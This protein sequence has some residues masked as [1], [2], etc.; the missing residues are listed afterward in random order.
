MNRILMFHLITSQLAGSISITR[1]FRVQSAITENRRYQRKFIQNNWFCGVTLPSHWHHL[2]IHSVNCS[3]IQA[4]K[5][6]WEDWY[7]RWEWHGFLFSIYH[8]PLTIFLNEQLFISKGTVTL[9]SLMCMMRTFQMLNTHEIQTE[10]V[11]K[12]ALINISE[13]CSF[14]CLTCCSLITR[15]VSLAEWC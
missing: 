5:L 3:K 7:S 11:R 9:S 6:T 4:Y 2:K 8:N 10:I 15:T 14:S 1:N 13:S 12:K